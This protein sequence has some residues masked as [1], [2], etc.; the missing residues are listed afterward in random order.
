MTFE[1]NLYLIYKEM[2]IYV[3]ILDISYF[4]IKKATLLQLH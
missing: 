4:L 2:K 1:Y 3:F